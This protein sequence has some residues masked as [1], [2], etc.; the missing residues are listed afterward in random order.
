MARG[1]QVL[2][3]LAN[4][5]DVPADELEESIGED[6]SASLHDGNR[7]F[8]RTVKEEFDVAIQPTFD[9]QVA[10]G[11]PYGQ[12]E[13]PADLV[14]GINKKH[15]IVFKDPDFLINLADAV[16]RAA[17]ARRTTFRVC[18]YC[19]EYL[20]PENME[21]KT[22]CHGCASVHEGIIY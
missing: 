19:R 15:E 2:D 18:K 4:I 21:S 6:W 10:V 13:G 12:W 11:Q 20:P 3:E 22:L 1:P 9:G 5:L 8:F 14:Y 17:L 7:I 16:D